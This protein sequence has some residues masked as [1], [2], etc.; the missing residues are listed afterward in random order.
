MVLVTGP[1]TDEMRQKWSHS[2]VTEILSTLT[3]TDHIEK[4]HQSLSR[5]SAYIARG[6]VFADRTQ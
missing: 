3:Y 2:P 4:V 5:V 6:A 1:E